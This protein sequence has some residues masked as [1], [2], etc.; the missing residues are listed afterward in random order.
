MPDIVKNTLKKIEDNFKVGGL[1]RY[2]INKNVFCIHINSIV[3]ICLSELGYT[4]VA[5]KNLDQVIRS[6]LFSEKDNLFFREINDKNE[7]TIFTF[8]VCKNALAVLSLIA[9]NKIE[10][11]KK[12]IDSLYK[13]PLF[14]KT[15]GLFYREMHSVSKE[16]NSLILSQTNLWMVIALSKLHYT[17]NASQLMES[18]EKNLFDR[19]TGMSFS[20]DCEDAHTT[21]KIFFSDDQ[22]L[23]AIAYDC[24]GQ[25]NK[26]KSVLEKILNSDLYDKKSGMFNRD[27]SLDNVVNYTKNT[28]KNSLLCIA[29]N[30]LG[31]RNEC[32]KVQDGLMSLLFDKDLSLFH[33]SD[34]D[35][36]KIPDNST[37]ALLALLED[38]KTPRFLA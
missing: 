16:I 26:A 2:S 11:A 36:T 28:Y 19:S 32:K 23:A 29:L 20:Q 7:I 3:N 18:I 38:H 33:F 14:D 10:L 30:R 1:Y 24:I 21:A 37:L 12:I 9:D 31:F 22:G 8:N 27:I 35:T 4:A 34:V 5:S 17:T 13:S 25:Q 15:T 6:K